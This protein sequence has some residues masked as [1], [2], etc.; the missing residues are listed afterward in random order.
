MVTQ[1]GFGNSAAY[2]VS[3]IPFL[4]ASLAIPVLGSAP[5]KVMFPLITKFV[6]VRNDLDP[7]ATNVQLR[8]GFSSTGV[9]GT[10]Q[11]NYGLLNNGESYTGDWRVNSVYLLSNSKT[12]CS[13]SV[14]VG[15]TGIRYEATFDNFSGSMN[16]GD[17][18]LGG[19]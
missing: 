9:S 18:D 15:M 8:Y 5:L 13:G 6:S 16:G 11:Q 3:A 7:S 12:P 1:S 19:I 14:V 17:S 4:S 10:V 2:V